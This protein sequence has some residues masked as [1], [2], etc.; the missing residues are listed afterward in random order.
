MARWFYCT[1]LSNFHRK[2]N[3]NIP[4]IIPQNINSRNI[5]KLILSPTVT[6]IPIPHKKSTKHELFKPIYLMNIDAKIL[7]NRIQE[8]S[9]NSI[10]H[11]QV[12]FIQ[13]G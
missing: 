8:H 13:V 3:T 7:P 11:D 6:L 1:I 4:Q 10:H 12:G 5:R 9:K 2:T